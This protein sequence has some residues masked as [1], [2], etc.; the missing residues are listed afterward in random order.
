VEFNRIL[1]SVVILASSRPLSLF[2]MLGLVYVPKCPPL[3]S[4]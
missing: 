4:T 2:V 3:S 1:S